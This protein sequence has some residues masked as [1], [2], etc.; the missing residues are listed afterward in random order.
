MINGVWS[1]NTVGWVIAAALLPPLAVLLLEQGAPAA[2]RIT[3]ALAV[4]AGWQL[5]FR[6][7]AGVPMS[8]TAALTAVAVGVLA[9]G[10]M[11]IW[12]LALAV[13]FGTVLG[14][15]VFGGWGRNVLSPAVVTLAF[16]F[17]S[18][19]EIRH[20]P[21][22]PWVALA[23]APAAILLMATGILSWRVLAASGTA[24]VAA[25]LAFDGE[26]DTM[27]VLGGIAFGLVFL[28]GDPVS[29]PSTAAGRTLYGALTGA[30][31][32]YLGHQYGALG[33]PQTIVFAALLTS[34]FAPLLDHAVIAARAYRRRL[35]H[36]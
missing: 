12:Q 32:G 5:A 8:P 11:A 35:W 25:A 34:I 14:E 27:P 19:P 9:S 15:L 7:G 26:L 20:A 28:V 29:S 10:E 21:A 1:R 23:C 18:F 16:A 3:M 6:I 31:M 2:L 36:G 33:A 4:I 22:G 30:L 13:T 24:L 17:V